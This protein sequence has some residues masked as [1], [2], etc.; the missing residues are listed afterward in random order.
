MVKVAPPLMAAP[1]GLD[2]HFGLVVGTPALLAAAAAMS[3]VVVGRGQAA[4]VLAVV[5]L[6][7]AIV[8]QTVLLAPGGMVW[9]GQ[10]EHLGG[11]IQ[12]SPIGATV[13]LL[14][15]VVMAGMSDPWRKA[16]SH[17]AAWCARTAIVL[18]LTVWMVPA[19]ILGF[20][21]DH[22][23]ANRFRPLRVGWALMATVGTVMGAALPWMIAT[24]VL[25]AA[26]VEGRWRWF[27][28][29]SALALLATVIMRELV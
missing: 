6:L 15:A 27:C 26:T 3:V 8:L 28:G 25:V 2:Q 20:E 11:Y 4:R 5:G 23:H 14:L 17:P 7:P 13:G 10:G 16:G 18:A 22:P 21:D 24:L 1:G 29:L 19:F 9:R 12:V